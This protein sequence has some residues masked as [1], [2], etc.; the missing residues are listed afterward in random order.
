MKTKQKQ[1]SVRHNIQ[2]KSPN[3][4]SAAGQWLTLVKKQAGPKRQECRL[5]SPKFR[6]K[7]G[8]VVFGHIFKRSKQQMRH[9]A[10]HDYHHAAKCLGLCTRGRHEHRHANDGRFP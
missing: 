9:R 2:Q 7:Q 6:P 5:Q 1:K 8:V 3:T 10:K 4:I